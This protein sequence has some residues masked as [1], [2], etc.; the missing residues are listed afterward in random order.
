[1]AGL[2]FARLSAL[3]AQYLNFSFMIVLPIGM[4]IQSVYTIFA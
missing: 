4:Y 2:Y 3:Y 1:M